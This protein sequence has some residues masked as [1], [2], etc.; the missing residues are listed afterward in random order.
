MEDRMRKNLEPKEQS[1][2]QAIEI[3]QVRNKWNCNDVS[4]NGDKEEADS[5][6]SWGSK[7]QDTFTTTWYLCS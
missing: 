5:R 3:V 1:I 2:K 4:G 7:R 6:D